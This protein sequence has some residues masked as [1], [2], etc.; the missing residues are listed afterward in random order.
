MPPRLQLPP[1]GRLLHRVL[2]PPARR[3]AEEAERHDL[4]IVAAGLSFYALLSVVPFLV[5][6]VWVTSLLLGDRQVERLAEVARSMAPEDLGADGAV[7]GVAEAGTRL[8]VAALLSGLWPATS[9]G[10]GLVRA[11][12]S[13]SPSEDREA[14]GVLGRILMLVALVPLFVIGSLL[15]ATAGTLLLEN[16]ALGVVLALATGFTGAV[17][18]VALIYR[19]FAP[20]R[21]SWWEI[22]RASP[23]AAG[24]IALL[25]VG[26]IL[27]MALGANFKEHYAASSVVGLVALALWVF[28]ANVVVLAVYAIVLE[29][30]EHSG[31]GAE[32]RSAGR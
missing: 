5:V 11:L 15:A 6:L 30:G 25:S 18:A 26:L 3:I 16:L 9:Y 1:L 31:E 4:L 17:V 23:M 28:L 24:A 20:I 10:A 8:G 14:P 19:F 12:D 7:Q 2:P 29:D 32:G 22:A 21:L 27:Y 13:V